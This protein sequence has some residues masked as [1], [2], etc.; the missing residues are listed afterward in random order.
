[1]DKTGGE[2]GL[3]AHWNQQ[4][5]HS[6]SPMTVGAGSKSMGT[7]VSVSSKYGSKQNKANNTDFMNK[8]TNVKKTDSTASCPS[9]DDKSIIDTILTKGTKGRKRRDNEQNERA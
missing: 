6:N 8:G 2:S 7:D 3:D 5:T 4:N 1:M 9:R